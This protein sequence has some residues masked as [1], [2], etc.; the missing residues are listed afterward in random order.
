MKPVAFLSALFFSVV[1][2][3]AERP[4]GMG[5]GDL[6]CYDGTIAKT[7]NLAASPPKTRASRAITA[8]RR[9]ARRRAVVS[10]PGS[11]RDVNPN[12]GEDKY[13]DV[14]FADPTNNKYPIDTAD[15]LHL[16]L[17]SYLRSISLEEKR[18]SLAAYEYSQA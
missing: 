7:P 6:G 17:S 13:G 18:A 5:Q 2:H 12:E 8:R 1:A 10:S 11:F 4:D 9:F 16:N 15:Q 14:Q 3:A